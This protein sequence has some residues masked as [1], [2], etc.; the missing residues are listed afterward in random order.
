MRRKLIALA[1]AAV[2][3]ALIA[4]DVPQPW[5]AVTKISALAYADYYGIVEHHDE[6]LEGKNGFLLRRIYLTFDRT[7]S[8]SLSARLRFEANQPGDFT[9][10]ANL[11]PYV[12]DAWV[13]WKK[14]DALE[15]TLGI[16]PTPTFDSIE[17]WWGYRAVEKTP[18]DLQRWSPSRDFGLALAGRGGPGNRFRYHFMAGNGAS[19]GS[20][21]NPGKQIS[22]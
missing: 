1:L 15:L 2:P 13:R 17:Q 14:S 4:Q 21:T 18:L 5:Y 19:T 8:P 10:G 7:I 22:L 20:E 12:K 3:T 11:E 6:D 16:S 9:S